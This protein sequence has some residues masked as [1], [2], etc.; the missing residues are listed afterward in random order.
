MTLKNTLAALVIGIASSPAFAAE[1]VGNSTFQVF[2]SA[3]QTELDVTV[4]YPSAGGGVVE[5]S[6]DDR[7]FE[8]TPAFKNATIQPGRLPLVVLSHGSGS[9]MGGMAW[10]ATALA[11]EGFVVAGT[12]HPGTT[13]GDSTP[14]DTPKIWQR[15][16]DLSTIITA[17]TTDSRWQTSI[18]EDEIG[19]LGFSLGGSAALEISGARADLGAYVRYCEDHPTMPDCRWFA[20]G[21]GYVD[22]EPASVPKLDLRTI[23]KARF[24]Q[25]NRD[26]RI[27]SAVLVDPGLALAFQ[28]ESLKEIDI[29]LTFI[30]LGSNGKIPVAVLADTLAAQVPA[31]TYQQVDE[32]DHFSFLPICKPDADAFLKS[33]GERDPICESAGKRDRKDIHTQ[34]ETM[35]VTAFNRTLKPRQ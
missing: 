17:L 29:P 9:S 25:Q 7:V 2:S 19:V 18:A 5:L 1:N 24:E 35:I 31:S 6:R 20:G 34:L 32:A 33:V 30:N 10:L 15:T 26:P 3:R 12:N 21:R 8:G 23:D 28:P 11:R 4:W 22:G 27:R 13:S 16:N 14:A